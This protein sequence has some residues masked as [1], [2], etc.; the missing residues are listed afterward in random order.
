[1]S[2]AQSAIKPKLKLWD[3][4]A[5]ERRQTEDPQYYEEHEGYL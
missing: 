3:V 5:R 2:D 1:M 4:F